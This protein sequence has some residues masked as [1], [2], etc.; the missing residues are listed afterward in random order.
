[1]AI[2]VFRRHETSYSFDRQWTAFTIPARCATRSAKIRLRDYSV[3]LDVDRRVS[4]QRWILRDNLQAPDDPG[5]P[6]HRRYVQGQEIYLTTCD[7]KA[8]ATRVI[9]NNDLKLPYIISQP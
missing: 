1:M 2:G 9:D 8:R 6:S 7:P 4:L 5:H 3:F